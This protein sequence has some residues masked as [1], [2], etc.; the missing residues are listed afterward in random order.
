MNKTLFLIVFGIVITS[1]K[2]NSDKSDL[3]GSNDAIYQYGTKNSFLMKDY[4][5]DLTFAELKN[6]GNFGLGTVNLIDGEMAALNSS[7]VRIPVNGDARIIDDTM[8]TPFAVVKFFHTDESYSLE[9]INSYS[10]LINEL[11]LLLGDTTKPVAIKITGSFSSAV[12]RSVH[13]QAEPFKP[14]DEIVADQVVFNLNNISGAVMGFR[15]PSYMDG[16]NFP[17]YHF[18]FLS[19]DL[20]KGGHMLELSAEK[21]LV[22]IDY[23]DKVIIE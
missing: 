21:L 18:H 23:T 10:S 17:G 15:F 5:G 7:F 12:T 6:H 4:V 3:T 14:L 9:N 1:C 8:K 13:R 11:D 16:V 22:E 19:S 20:K 2:T